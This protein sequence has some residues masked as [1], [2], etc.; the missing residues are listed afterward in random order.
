[1]HHRTA[2]AALVLLAALLNAPL[3]WTAPASADVQPGYTFTYTPKSGLTGTI[4]TFQATGCYHFGHA[5]DGA[6]VELISVVQNDRAAEARPPVAPD[7]SFTG[8]IHV[9][10]IPT[11]GAYL[12]VACYLQD[13][14]FLVAERMPF[15][16]TGS[17]PGAPPPA[18]ATTTTSAPTMTAL[19]TTTRRSPTTG[20][21][22]TKG[23]PP[24]TSPAATTDDSSA[25]PARGQQP[26][27][28]TEAAGPTTTGPGS[29]DTT[30]IGLDSPD[31][32]TP[33]TSDDPE[34]TQLAAPA[35]DQTPRHSSR[36]PWILITLLAGTAGIAVAA[37]TWKRRRQRP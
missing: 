18:W 11:G 30:T 2:P 35:A 25:D 32:T 7:G 29:P 17:G 28:G 19:P 12:G 22:T 3:A 27:G 1:M 4:I 16:V 33:M 6:T 10:E 34:D 24:G 26:T 9:P 14:A 8:Q 20:A 31:D 37:T 36:R 5:D 23:R 21:P 13:Q 15:D